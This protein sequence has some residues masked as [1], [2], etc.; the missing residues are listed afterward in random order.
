MNTSSN[1][2][3]KTLLS[4]LDIDPR[5]LCLWPLRLI[6]RRAHTGAT[7]HFLPIVAG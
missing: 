3:L 4:K 5:V 1:S 2:A 6:G 7:V